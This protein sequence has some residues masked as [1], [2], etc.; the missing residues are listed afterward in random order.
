MNIDTLERLGQMSDRVNALQQTMDD[1]GKKLA[2]LEGLEKAMVDIYLEFKRM[3]NT[4]ATAG[5]NVLDL[6]SELHDLIPYLTKT[7][8]V[9]E[10]QDVEQR[11]KNIVKYLPLVND[12]SGVLKRSCDRLGSLNIE[13]DMQQFKDRYEAEHPAEPEPVSDLPESDLVS[14]EPD[15]PWFDPGPD[16]D[17]EPVDYDPSVP[18]YGEEPASSEPE[19]IP[20]APD[21]DFSSEE[22]A[23]EWIGGEQDEPDEAFEPAEDDYPD[24][25]PASPEPEY[26]DYP[27][28]EEEQPEDDP[29]STK[30]WADGPAEGYDSDLDGDGDEPDDESDPYTEPE[31]EEEVPDDAGSFTDISGQGVNLSMDDRRDN[32]IEGQEIRNLADKPSREPVR[33]SANKVYPDIRPNGGVEGY[34]TADRGSINEMDIV[35]AVNEIAN[36]FYTVSNSPDIR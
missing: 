15:A 3:S 35:N 10:I 1:L 29:W 24:E 28:A 19:Y 18:D 13:Q 6:K 11:W 16:P 8:V 12:D 17:E 36:R 33:E 23:S 25:E 7:M 4:Y 14:D 26:D 22:Q 30:L 21:D 34:I 9:N 2:Q 5:R 27:E 20:A 31:P 32:S